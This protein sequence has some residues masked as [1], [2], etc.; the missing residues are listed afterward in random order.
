M[1]I[2]SYIKLEI[3]RLNSTHNL[4]G[5]FKLK[6]GN[7]CHGVCKSEVSFLKL[8]QDQTFHFQ[9]TVTGGTMKPIL[10]FYSTLLNKSEKMSHQ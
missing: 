9:P 7:N 2:N 5:N 8:F 10:K 3:E 1:N 6:F 4:P